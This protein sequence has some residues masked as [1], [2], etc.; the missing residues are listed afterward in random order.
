LRTTR[1]YNPEV[2]RVLDGWGVGRLPLQFER[3]R[4]FINIFRS[5]DG[6]RTL[7]DEGFQKVLEFTRH[8]FE[9]SLHFIEQ[10]EAELAEFKASQTTAPNKGNKKDR[11]VD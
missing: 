5:H 2:W 9:M 4:Q 1:N 7:S 8:S 3:E 11:K 6:A 10:Q